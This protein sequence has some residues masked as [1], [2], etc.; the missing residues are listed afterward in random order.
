MEVEAMSNR[1][2]KISRILASPISRRRAIRLSAAT[3]LTANAPTLLTAEMQER[4]HGEGEEGSSFQEYK[5]AIN[6]HL[7]EYLEFIEPDR[8]ARR[9]ILAAYE[10][11]TEIREQYQRTGFI[12]AD[13]LVEVISEG[14]NLFEMVPRNVVI[15]LSPDSSLQASEITF[16]KSGGGPVHIV[17]IGGN[18][19]FWRDHNPDVKFVSAAF[20]LPAAE[21]TLTVASSSFSIGKVIVVVAAFAIAI[22]I[23][24]EVNQRGRETGQRCDCQFTC[25]A[26]DGKTFPYSEKKDCCSASEV[27]NNT[28]TGQCPATLTFN[29]GTTCVLTSTSCVADPSCIRT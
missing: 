16:T 20:T 11:A 24:T 5:K 28:C 10:R 22:K 18:P 7:E 4:D 26:R 1:F 21:N 12:P 9:R 29:N 2:D 6:V 23:A 17:M 15:I 19:G 25:T 14:D 3:L 13:P 8:A 27:N